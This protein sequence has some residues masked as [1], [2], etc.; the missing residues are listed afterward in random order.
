MAGRLLLIGELTDELRELKTAFEKIGLTVEMAP[1]G[2]AGIERGTE[3]QPDLVVTEILM[4]PLSGFEL[5]SRIGSGEAGFAAP[6][7]FYT[8]FYRDDKAR[9]QVLAKYQAAQYFIRPFQKEDLKKSV[10]GY[11]NEFLA[12]RAVVPTGIPEPAST[13]TK[14]D[15]VVNEPSRFEDVA[16]QKLIIAGSEP[17]VQPGAGGAFK[18]PVRA[19]FS[20]LTAHSPA[21]HVNKTLGAGRMVAEQFERQQ[22]EK[23]N[24][25][26]PVSDKQMR[27][28]SAQDSPNDVL[29]MRRLFRST[30]FKIAALLVVAA[31][32]LYLIRDQLQSGS[33]EEPMPSAKPISA[34]PIPGSQASVGPAGQQPSPT[35][36]VA[37]SAP[38]EQ[39]SSAVATQVGAEPASSP[40]AIVPE[41]SV[42]STA[43]VNTKQDLAQKADAV[44]AK[45][46]KEH[47]STLSIQDVTGSAR[48]PVLKKM[49][50]IQLSEDTMNSLGSKSVVVR[51]VVDRTG[52]VKEV[53]PLNQQGAGA[54]L[55][56]DA[57]DTIHQWEFSRSRH[58]NVGDAVKYFRLRVQN[59]RSKTT[60]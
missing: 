5:S 26:A 39:R 35:S 41:G 16:G 14:A 29:G 2:L 9:R 38:L 60:D 12:E 30:V 56:A 11:F 31:L 28:A 44:E 55:P 32:T 1:D 48:G 17:P 37:P 51:V 10:A 58:K 47:S 27:P 40:T 13:A 45:T 43:E 22:G 46:V 24:P 52:K 57:I 54:I 21:G 36:M 34:Q 7:I 18:A 20:S 23:N 50:P 19:G 33:K 8:E 3:F 49:T 53:T 15:A 6:V 25:A 4:S 59:S 42:S